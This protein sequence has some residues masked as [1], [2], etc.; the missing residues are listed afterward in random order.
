MSYTNLNLTPNDP[1]F[2]EKYK[3]VIDA[4]A[5][6]ETHGEIEVAFTT[7]AAAITW[8]RKCYEYQKITGKTFRVEAGAGYTLLLRRRAR[9]PIGDYG[10]IKIKPV[11]PGESPSTESDT[12]PS[13]EGVVVTEADMEL[14]KKVLERMAEEGEEID[15]LAVLK[16]GSHDDS[17]RSDSG[18]DGTSNGSSGGDD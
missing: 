15:P 9:R 12:V 18:G 7:S 10:L 2:K 6:L 1:D 4:V 16:G 5:Q 8:R 13:T 3:S 11:R 17:G 14:A